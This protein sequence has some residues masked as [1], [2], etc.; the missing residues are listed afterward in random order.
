ML[1]HIIMKHRKNCESCWSQ[2]TWKVKFECQSCPVLSCDD[3]HVY[4]DHHDHG[5]QE[6]V[7]GI[8]EEVRGCLISYN[9]QLACVSKLEV[10]RLLKLI[11]ITQ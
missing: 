11:V 1:V 4:H 6:E 10:I 5:N 9:L 3:H 8:Y 7:G 2:D